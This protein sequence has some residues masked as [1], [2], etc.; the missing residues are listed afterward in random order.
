MCGFAAQ[1]RTRSDD[2]SA[3]SSALGQPA[4]AWECRKA[5][6]SRCGKKDYYNVFV[7]GLEWVVGVVWSMA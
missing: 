2:Q 1:Q 6:G 5:L 4:G 7:L 3:I